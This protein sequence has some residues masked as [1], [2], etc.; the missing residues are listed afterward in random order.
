VFSGEWRA[1]AD[2]TYN[3]TG[4]TGSL[5]SDA[6]VTVHSSAVHASPR[7]TED[8][9]QLAAANSPLERLGR[10]LREFTHRNGG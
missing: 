8:L 10:Y 6:F 1:S 7:A 9:T 3:I 4:V 2:G 5:R